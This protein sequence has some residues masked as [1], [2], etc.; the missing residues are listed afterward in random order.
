MKLSKELNIWVFPAI[1][2]ITVVL[3]VSAGSLVL[4][5]IVVGLIATIACWI[6]IK[7]LPLWAKNFLGKHPLIADVICLKLSFLVFALLG[8]GVTIF[9]ALMTQAVVL[10]ILLHTLQ[11]EGPTNGTRKHQPLQQPIQ[12]AA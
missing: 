2:A 4:N 3:A 8:S 6:T 12:A 5:G 10:G 11:Q 9:T 1:A 7:K